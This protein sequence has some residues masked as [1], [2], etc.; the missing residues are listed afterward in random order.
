MA[1]ADTVKSLMV[2]MLHLRNCTIRPAESCKECLQAVAVQSA[3]L[4]ES[5]EIA[6]A[7]RLLL[8]NAP[9]QPLR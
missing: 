2:G 7:L 4:S 9:A 8:K 6:D 1:K 3:A 5:V